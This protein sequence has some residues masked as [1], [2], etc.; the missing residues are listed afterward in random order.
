MHDAE[1]ELSNQVPGV[2]GDQVLDGV[3]LREKSHPH[4]I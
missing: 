4:L 1:H 3:R 2:Q